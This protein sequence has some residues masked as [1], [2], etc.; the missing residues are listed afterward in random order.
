MPFQIAGKPFKDRANRDACFFKMVTPEYFRALGM[1]FKK[2]A[3]WR[4]P[5]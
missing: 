2:G 4:Q 1:Q 5:T 3:A